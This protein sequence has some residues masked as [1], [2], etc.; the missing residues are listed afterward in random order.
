MKKVISV[1][2]TVLNVLSLL[3][4]TVYSFKNNVFFNE[5]ILAVISYIV[6]CCDLI[7]ASFFKKVVSFVQIILTA[8]LFMINFASNYIVGLSAYVPSKNVIGIVSIVMIFAV[9]ILFISLNIKNKDYKKYNINPIAALLC[10]IVS[11]LF[12]ISIFI[13]GLVSLFAKT[14]INTNTVNLAVLFILLCT[15]IISLVLITA[16]DVKFKHI[17]TVSIILF[18]AAVIPF[19]IIQLSVLADIKQADE[20]FTNVFSD[21]DVK[22]N[23]RKIP[24]SFADE[25]IGIE[26]ADFEIQRDVVYYSAQDGAD[27]GLTLH[28]DMYL[29]KDNNAHKAVL[30]NLHGSGGDKD[31]GNYAHRNKYFASRG[32]VVFDLQFGDWN[33]NNTGFKEEM[34]SSENMLFHIDKFF[35]YLSKNNSVG[36]DLSEV[37]IT[38]VSMGGGL[39]SKYAYSYDNSLNEYGIVLK[40]IIPVYPG[41][42]P[43]SEGIDN[44]LNYVDNDSVPCMVVMGKSDCIVRTQTLAET[45]DAYKMASNPNC[46]ALEIS[47]AG[48]GCDSLVTGRSNQMITY[49]AE[50]FMQ[51]Q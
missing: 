35:E 39:A 26:M 7:Y 48:H 36:A 22:D 49:Y 30:I 23:M 51:R 1:I 32:Y 29:P 28:Y 17:K 18:A 40:G 47:Y 13:V 2:L 25:F 10:L 34:Y 41:Y 38:G 46:F 9:N 16:D 6:I 45:L 42:S 21:I 8:L 14:P 31:I 50:Q 37:F 24:Y 20:V 11:I 43:E 15:A 12:F 4:F 33:E 3:F 5:N 19:A 27:K 44:Y